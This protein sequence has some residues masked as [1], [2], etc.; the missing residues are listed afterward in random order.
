[1]LMK[2]DKDRLWAKV[3]SLQANLEEV[4]GDDNKDE[5]AATGEVSGMVGGQ[6][7]PGKTQYSMASGSPQRGKSM[8][9]MIQPKSN[10]PK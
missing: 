2:L 1:M 8:T 10:G 7:S 5:K 6:N 3:G 4:R 9:Q